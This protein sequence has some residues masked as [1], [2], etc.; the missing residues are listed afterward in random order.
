VGVI[1]TAYNIVPCEGST[2]HLSRDGDL[3]LN[4]GLQADARLK[5][6]LDMVRHSRTKQEAHNLLNNLARGVQI[7]KTLVNFEFI[8]IPG[9]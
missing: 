7:D 5:N 4:T 2:L 1:H 8:T 3:D 6:A 9:L